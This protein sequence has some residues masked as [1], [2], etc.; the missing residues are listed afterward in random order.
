MS[1]SKEGDFT[2]DQMIDY[3]IKMVEEN[4]GIITI[5]DGLAGKVGLN[6]MKN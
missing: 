3:I 5:E 2:S 1:R 4:P 6:Y